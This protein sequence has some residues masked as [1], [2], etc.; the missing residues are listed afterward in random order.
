MNVLLVDDEPL[1]LEQLEFLIQ[2]LFSS[3]KFYKALDGVEFA[4][5]IGN[6][7]PVAA[8]FRA[9]FFCS[10]FPANQSAFQKQ[11]ETIWP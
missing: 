8:L 5:L 4:D 6:I 3:W 7:W 2:P 9:V 11:T 10:C 1:E